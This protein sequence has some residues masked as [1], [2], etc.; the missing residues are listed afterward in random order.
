M[1]G[2]QFAVFFFARQAD[3]ALAAKNTGS[4]LDACSGVK[5]VR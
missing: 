1:H 3:G 5:D 2:L 4:A